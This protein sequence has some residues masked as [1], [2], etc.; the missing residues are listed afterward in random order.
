MA[1]NSSYEI[2]LWRQRIGPVGVWL[3]ASKKQAGRTLTEAA[4]AI[5]DLGFGALWIGSGNPDRQSFH[6]LAA[7]LDATNNLTVAPGI[8]NIWAWDPGTMHTTSVGIDEKYPGRFI[9]GLGVSH[10]RFVAELGH[11]YRRPL[12]AMNNFLDELDQIAADSGRRMPFT[13]LAALRNRMLEVARHRSGGAHPY[14][15][16]PTH[17]AA[18]R[19]VLGP[20]RLLAPEQAVVLETDPMRARIIAREYMELYLSLPNYLNSLR[21]FGFGD[22][23]F[24]N[25]GSDRLVD[26]IVAWGS[27]ETVAARVQEHLNSG[28]DHVAIQPLDPKGGFGLEQLRRLAPAVL[29]KRPLPKGYR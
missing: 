8:A 22:K 14:F 12:T 2:D 26:A 15:M 11:E 13:V 27:V 20:D 28:A 29:S 10:P 1:Q 16:T 7:L 21:E 18:A 4:V 25:H 5:E 24:A 3:P 6:D 23:D 9:V 17:T 19:R